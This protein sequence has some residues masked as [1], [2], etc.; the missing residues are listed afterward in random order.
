M[1]R[2]IEV[3]RVVKGI[4]QPTV[5]QVELAG[6]DGL[7]PTVTIRTDKR[8]R[9]DTWRSVET[10]QCI[11]LPASGG[12]GFQLLKNDHERYDSFVGVDAADHRCD[13]L[14]H[15][16]HGYCKHCDALSYLCQLGLLPDPKQ[17][18]TDGEL[19]VAI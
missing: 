12:R 17:R 6:A 2:I 9:S 7:F 3:P 16:H 11:E 19:H 14:G 4:L 1:N 8:K 10:Y 5:I 13:C 18:P 15:L